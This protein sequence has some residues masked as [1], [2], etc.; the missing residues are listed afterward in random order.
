MLHRGSDRT[1]AVYGHVEGIERHTVGTVIHHAFNP[2]ATFSTTKVP[3]D[4]YLTKEYCNFSYSTPSYEDPAVQISHNFQ[5]RQCTSAPEVL[6]L[7]R[8]RPEGLETHD[9]CWVDRKNE[10]GYKLFY[11]NPDP[12]VTQNPVQGSEEPK[13]KR[14]LFGRAKDKALVR[15]EDTGVGGKCLAIFVAAKTHSKMNPM[16]IAGRVRW[17]DE[18]WDEGLPGSR[19]TWGEEGRVAAFLA[20]MAY[21]EKS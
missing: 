5:W 2:S 17:C 10:R 13:K 4:A 6:D 21:L 15:K 11:M 20:L 1:G 16:K 18:V 3:I 14:S 19:N 12:T 8:S 9:W 7:C